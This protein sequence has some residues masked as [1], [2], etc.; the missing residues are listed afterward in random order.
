MPCCPAF[1]RLIVL[2]SLV[3]S[4]RQLLAQQQDSL[5]TQTSPQQ[6]ALGQSAWIKGLGLMVHRGFNLA[7]DPDIAH[8]AYEPSIGIQADWQPTIL[9][10]PKWRR[11]YRDAGMGFTLL[12]NSNAPN[13]ILGTSVAAGAYLESHLLRRQNHKITIRGAL[14]PVWSSNPFDLHDNPLNQSIGSRWSALVQAQVSWHY[15]LSQ[16]FWARTGVSLIHYSNGSFV[17]P[18]FGVNIPALTVGIVYHREG[19]AATTPDQQRIYDQSI[20]YRKGWYIRLGVQGGL[21]ENFPTSGPKYMTFATQGFAGYRFNAKA[22]LTSGLDYMY[23]QSIK[24]YG[25]RKPELDSRDIHRVGL[26]GGVEVFIS[27]VT[28]HTQVGWYLYKHFPLYGPYYQRVTLSYHWHPRWQS[29][30]ALKLHNL[31]AETLEL[32]TTFRVF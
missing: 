21:V 5:A 9:V 7:H 12:V 30:L 27:K 25:E 4:G 15:R 16:D 28:I 20:D 22:A 23:N 2:L 11:L 14:G 31:S 8:V 18:N 3:V 19:E 24:A 29:G 1:L 13:S 26:T 17:M 32:M 10:D 6:E